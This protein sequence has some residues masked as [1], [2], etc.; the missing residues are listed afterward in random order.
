MTIPSEAFLWVKALHI[1]SVVCWFAA[2]F[3]LPRLYVYHA[4]TDKD[5]ITAH[6]R[7]QIMERKL[8]RGIMWPAMIATLIT[9]HFLVDWGDALFHYHQS[10]WFYIKVALVGLLVLYHLS[11]GYYRKKLI[12]NAHYKSHKFWRFFNELP[13]VILFAC[14]ILVVVK[15]TF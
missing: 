9:A 6:Q 4:M 3:Y 11:C 1:I 7:F 10:A 13:T 8:Y 5:D 14:V 12:D 2:L 15:P